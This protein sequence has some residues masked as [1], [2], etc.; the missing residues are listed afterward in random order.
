ML[1]IFRARVVDEL[2]HPH[3]HVGNFEA[4]RC[5]FFVFLYSE[6]ESAISGSFAFHPQERSCLLNTE[7]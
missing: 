2:K 4:V 1:F 7:Q 3:E 5:A 6:Y